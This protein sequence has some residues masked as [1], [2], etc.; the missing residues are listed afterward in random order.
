MYATKPPG[1]DYDAVEKLELPMQHD[2]SSSS[3]RKR[4]GHAFATFKNSD[5]AM[6]CIE[7]VDGQSFKGKKL[8]LKL[9][10]EGVARARMGDVQYLMPSAP[11]TRSAGSSSRSHHGSR[12]SE[13]SGQRSSTVGS[14]SGRSSQASG[15]AS[16]NSAVGAVINRGRTPMVVDSSSAEITK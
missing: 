13:S 12:R 3:S 2:P 1:L 6:N 9:T 7:A 10:K 5:M 8:E 16:G 4:R 14:S 15:V 11:P